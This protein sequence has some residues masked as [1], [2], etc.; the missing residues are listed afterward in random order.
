M[1]ITFDSMKP[2]EFEPVSLQKLEGAD[3]KKDPLQVLESC[4]DVLTELSTITQWDSQQADAKLEA[5]FATHGDDFKTASR[6]YFSANLQG[7]S[8]LTSIGPVRMS[9]KSKGKVHDRMRKT[10]ALAVPRIPEILMHGEVSDF[11]PLHKERSDNSEGFYEFKK[12]LEF[13]DFKIEA[14]I[15]VSQDAQ[16][17]L[18]YYLA[19]AKQKSPDTG[20][21]LGSE[22]QSAETGLNA[23]KQFDAASS[24]SSKPNSDDEVNIEILQVV[25]TATGKVIQEEEIETSGPAIAFGR[26]NNVKTAK[27]TKI[28]TVFALVEAD[29]L[30]AVNGGAKLSH[31]APL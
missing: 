16:G 5:L 14:M 12:W 22:P 27:G 7:M 28:A 25:T 21:M 19:A 4:V 1:N 8:V 11:I 10:K 3:P 15:K 23:N 17:K 31:L 26:A 24:D 9:A 29:D 30:I 2:D 13:P 6:E 20:S 18:L